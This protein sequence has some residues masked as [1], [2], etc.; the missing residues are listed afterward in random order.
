MGKDDDRWSD[1]SRSKKDGDWDVNYGIK[2]TDRKGHAVYGPDKDGDEGQVLKFFRTTDQQILVDKKES[3]S[4]CYI[5]TA[6]LKGGGSDAQLNFLR[7]WRDD[8]LNSTKLGRKMEQFYDMTGPTVAARVRGNFI[9][10]N[11]F[12]YPF[13]KPAVWLAQQRRETFW[14]RPAYDLLIF[15]IFLCGLVYGSAVY[16]FCKLT[17]AAE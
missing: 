6:T 12:L 10:A 3:S 1:A 8:V 2:H 15:A 13:V 16:L 5:A 4:G 17:S 9:L 7:Q 14:I 11:T